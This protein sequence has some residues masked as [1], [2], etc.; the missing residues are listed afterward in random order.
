MYESGMTVRQI[1][2]KVN[3]PPTTVAR[4]LKN[5]GV[6]LR[7]PGAPHNPILDDADFLRQEYEGGKSTTEIGKE[8]GVTASRVREWLVRHGIKTRSAGSS[9]GHNRCTPSARTKMSLAK[10][11]NYLGESNPNWRGGVPFLDPERNRFAARKWAADIKDR[12]NWTCQ[13]CGETNNLHAHHIRRWKDYP[14]LRYD[15]DNG[16]TLCH[17]CHAKAHGKGFV[18]PW[19]KHAKS[20]T[21]ASPLAKG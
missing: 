8:I 14:E 21:S 9:R 5:A 18:F 19:D 17:S 7:N 11:G 4:Y 1:G 2:A 16:I 15:L 10:R 12:D 3:V 13:E 20:P 6:Q